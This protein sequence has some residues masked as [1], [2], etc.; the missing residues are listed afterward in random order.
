MAFTRKQMEE[1]ARLHPQTVVIVEQEKKI[2]APSIAVREPCCPAWAAALQ[3]GSNG[4]GYSPLI[5]DLD[6]DIDIGDRLPSV[7]FCPWCGVPKT[8]TPPA[9]SP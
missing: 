4:D 8:V 5:L 2:P 1:F 7:R 3:P 9:P 6:D